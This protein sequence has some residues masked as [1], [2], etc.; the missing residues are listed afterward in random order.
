[1]VGLIAP[2]WPRLRGLARQGWLLVALVMAA[3][4]AAVPAPAL[5]TADD[6]VP[7]AASGAQV[8]AVVSGARDG[9]GQVDAAPPA[10]SIDRPVGAVMIGTDGTSLGEK[11]YAAR[12]DAGRNVVVSF[13]RF[14][15]VGRSAVAVGVGGAP[16]GLP[17]AG[18]RLTSGYGMR[19]HPIL[20]GQ[21]MHSGLDL[22]L[23]YG[24]PIRATADGTVISAGWAGG[25]GL[26]VKLDHGGAVET[27]YGHMSRLAVRAGQSV[28]KGQVIGFVGSTGRSTGP[29]VHY[30]VRRNSVAV[31]PL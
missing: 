22:A 6:A 11:R 31:K 3:M 29:H 5:A 26:A 18:A 14:R 10:I 4:I 13:S 28:R 25:Y 1:M 24:S 12:S 21:R 9:A 2:A 15:Q 16:A 8:T 7:V 20:G 23:P 30:E 17:V 27:L 19:H